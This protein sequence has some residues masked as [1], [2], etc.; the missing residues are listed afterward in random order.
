MSALGTALPNKTAVRSAAPKTI[1]RDFVKN[2]L[3]GLGKTQSGLARLL[4]IDDTAVSNLINGKRN[5]LASEVPIIA[6]YLDISLLDLY[7]S[8][9][10][11]VKV[12]AI[13]VIGE[14]W[15]SQVTRRATDLTVAA[16]PFDGEPIAH[17]VR[18]DSNAPRYRDGEIVICVRQADTTP[19]DDIG[20]ECLVCTASGELHFGMLRAGDRPD[21]FIV[22][23]LDTAAP[24]IVSDKLDWTAPV[25][26]HQPRPRQI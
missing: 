19:A 5:I 23:P 15:G 1:D 21:L 12:E 9:G 3:K 10:L 7:R 18:G 22:V 24:P 20:K 26:W 17:V 2:R 4:Q 14:I 16:P 25:A 13:S 11:N 8:F 6:E